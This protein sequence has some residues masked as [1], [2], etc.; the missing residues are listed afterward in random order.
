M[1]DEL[2]I[3]SQVAERKVGVGIL[4]TNFY[5]KNFVNKSMLVLI[6]RDSAIAVY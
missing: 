1:R 5:T 6:F 3:T 2:H 4:F